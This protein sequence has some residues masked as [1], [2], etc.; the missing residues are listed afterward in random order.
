MLVIPAIDLLGSEVVR[1]YQGR[2]SEEKKYH[3][4]PEE[5]V[6][7]FVEAGARLIHIVDLEGARKGEP[8]HKDLIL[9]LA[10]SSGAKLEVGGGIRNL[11]TVREYLEGG[12]ERVILGT[13]AHSY[14][15]LVDQLISLFP[16]RI[17]IGIDAFRGKV[18]VAGWEEETD[19]DFIDLAKR[20]DREGIRAIIYTEI[21]RDGTL[22][23]PN[24]W[25]IEQILKVVNVPVI[26]SGGISN[27]ED[28]L[29]L[30]RFEAQGLEGV[31]VGKAIYEKKINLKEAIKLAEE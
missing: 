7:E 11:D 25:G 28:I 24:F 26:A 19:L 23:G 4:T 2:F 13:V 1:L 14:P 16:Q 17:V 31:I 22:K 10:Q 12:V 27:L 30:K 20:Y 6:N 5:L 18:S 9:K 15:E 21:E 3:L 29:A 8:V